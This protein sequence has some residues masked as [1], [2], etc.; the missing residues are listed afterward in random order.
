M[1]LTLD[2][3]RAANIARQIHWGGVENWTLADWSNAMAGEAGET[4]NVV[5]KIRRVELG[6]TGNKASLE[7]YH[8]QLGLE[9]GDVLIYLDLLAHAAGLSLEE[10][11]R[12]SFNDKSDELKMPIRI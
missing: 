8:V 2:T 1:S 5:K 7:S 10:C 11:V 12:R 6:T 3:L 4:C 9:I